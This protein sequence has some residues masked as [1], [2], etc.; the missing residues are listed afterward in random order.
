MMR[1]LSPI[2]EAIRHYNLNASGGYEQWSEV[3]RPPDYRMHVRAM[4]F[5]VTGH[6][7]L[8]D[9]IFGW[10]TDISLEKVLVDIVEFG[11]SL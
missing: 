7:E 11:A 1:T 3:A 2:G 4:G 10:L 6:D 5:E 8:R 9:I